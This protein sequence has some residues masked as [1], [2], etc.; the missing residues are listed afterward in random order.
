M[1]NCPKCGA[2]NE[3]GVL[4]C[5][6]CGDRLDLQSVRPE[7]NRGRTGKEWDA[8]RIAGTVF[9]L[10]T[11]AV[12]LYVLFLGWGL[13]ARP[14]GLA[15]SV[16]ENSVM[17][18]AQT[19]ADDMFVTAYK[20]PKTYEFTSAEL[21]ALADGL[22]RLPVAAPTGGAGMVVLPEHLEIV[23]RSSNTMQAF[24]RLKMWGMTVYNTVLFS[25]DVA[26]DSTVK[27]RVLNSWFG[28]TEVPNFLQDKFLARFRTVI[29]GTPELAFV[30][31]HGK[32]LAAEDG[33]LTF[34]IPAA[35]T[36]KGTNK[37]IYRDLQSIAPRHKRDTRKPLLLD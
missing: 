28:T 12:L 3:I 36:D 31:K 13:F 24:L 33:T 20:V 21:T 9:K 10:F 25:L 2:G 29:A 15:G 16:P 8:A 7:V 17:E 23:V 35:L 11:L 26:D 19:K 4:F 32:E 5:R 6:N 18:A 14:M 27:I 37:E 34:T 30:L 22:C 1:I